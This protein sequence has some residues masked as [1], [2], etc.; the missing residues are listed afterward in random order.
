M[1]YLKKIRHFNIYDLI[2]SIVVLGCFLFY[3]FFYSYHLYYTEQMQLFRVTW[4]YIFSYL[5]KPAALAN[6]LGDFFTQFYYL[7]FG[8]AIVISSFIIILWTSL[9]IIFLRIVKSKHI[10][11]IPLLIVLAVSY[12][13]TALLYNLG[14]TIALILTAFWTIFYQNLKNKTI[15]IFIGF[16]SVPFLYHTVGAYFLFFIIMGL[17]FELK[18]LMNKKIT[19]PYLIILTLFS[20]IY[21]QLTRKHFLLTKTQAYIYPINE[22]LVAKP[23]FFLEKLLSLDCE[24]YFNNPGQVIEK[25]KKYQVHNALYSYYYNLALSKQKILPDNLMDLYQPGTKALFIPIEPTQ[26]PIVIGFSNEF[27]YLLGDVNEAQHA[28]I[29]ATIFSPKAQSSRFMRRMIEI[30]IVNGE[31]A[32]ASKYIKILE[33][34]LFHKKWASGMK[35]F[36]YNEEECRKSRWIKEKREQIPVNDLLKA[37]YNDIPQTL[38]HLVE[39]HPENKIALDYLLCYYLLN[40]DIESFGHLIIDH[41]NNKNIGPLPVLYQQALMIYFTRNPGDNNTIKSVISPVVV[42][43]FQKYSQIYEQTGGNGNFL[44]KDYSKTYWFYYH[45]ATFKTN[46]KNEKN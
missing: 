44:L 15:R 35:K 37:T 14:S 21:P 3:G 7:Q 28:T 17:I 19:I 31:Y 25:V 18:I 4:E 1:N 27:Y 38:K 16:V 29:L 41:N 8:G 39:N 6:Y 33:T 11:I 30:N 24:W 23:D 20:V 22:R 9:K 45:F 46:N 42:A 12:L 36:L 26:N 40:K 34:T 2:I 5:L 13:H 43:S 10:L 32:V